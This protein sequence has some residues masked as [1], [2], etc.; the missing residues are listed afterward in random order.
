MVMEWENFYLFYLKSL[1]LEDKYYGLDKIMEKV[2]CILGLLLAQTLRVNLEFSLP[3]PILSFSLA[4]L[5]PSCFVFFLSSV[6]L[7]PSFLFLL[8]FS[9]TSNLSRHLVAF[10]FVTKLRSGCSSLDSQFSGDEGK[11]R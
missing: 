11:E 6:P 3:S 10:T 1:S 2:L 5:S 4:P 7:F 9:H 8:A